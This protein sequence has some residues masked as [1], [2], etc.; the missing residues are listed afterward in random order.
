M[1]RPVWLLLISAVL[2]T[3]CSRSFE[4]DAVGIRFEP[5]ASMKLLKEQPGSPA[6][7]MFQSGLEIRSIPGAAPSIAE[8]ML[9]ASFEELRKT[10]G[11]ELPGEIRSA[12]AGSIP[13]GP[14]ARY[15]LNR[16][17]EYTLVYVVPSNGR[18]VLITLTAPEAEYGRL[19][20]QLERSLATLAVR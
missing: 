3:G 7:A 11:L 19:Q 17:D 20:K 10:S 8:P 1:K 6:V 18:Y 9:R 12:R 13:A 2:S 5:P 4:S 15:E 14:V 16:G